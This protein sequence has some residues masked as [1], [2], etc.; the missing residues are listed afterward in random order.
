L[1]IRHSKVV[2]NALLQTFFTDTQIYNI[3]GYISAKSS[4]PE[5]IISNEKDI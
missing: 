4:A 1:L 3:L 2:K 5:Q